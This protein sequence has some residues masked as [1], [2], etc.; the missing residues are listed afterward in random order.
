MEENGEKKTAIEKIRNENKL[1][2][3]KYKQDHEN[4]LS[5]NT[6]TG[7]TAPSEK[8]ILPHPNVETQYQSGDMDQEQMDSVIQTMITQREKEVEEIEQTANNK[9]FLSDEYQRGVEDT[10]RIVDVEIREHTNTIKYLENDLQTL[11]STVKGM[12]HTLSS[13]QGVLSTRNKQTIQFRYTELKRE[14]DIVT[15]QIDEIYKKRIFGA[16]S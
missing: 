11:C 12:S 6:D 8:G 3:L 10:R 15:K 9:L 2:K 14:Y 16:H 13:M 5:Q 7:N 4:V 1:R